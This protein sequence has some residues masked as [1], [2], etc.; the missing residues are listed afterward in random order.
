MALAL[1]VVVGPRLLAEGLEVRPRD[2]FAL[3]RRAACGAAGSAAE[4]A[5]AEAQ[6]AAAAPP[7]PAHAGAASAATP[8]PSAAAAAAAAGRAHAADGAWRAAVGSAPVAAAWER[9]C[10]AVVQEFVY[11]S[12]YAAV[13]PDTEF[14]A[15]VRRLLNAAFGEVARRA[16]SQRVDWGAVL[17]RWAARGAQG[18]TTAAVGGDVA[19][20]ARASGA[21]RRWPVA[22][23]L[24]VACC[25][26][27][28]RVAAAH[29][30]RTSRPSPQQRLEG[31]VRRDPA[32]PACRAACRRPRR[33]PRGAACGA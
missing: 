11:D 19:A 25:V 10:G 14:P 5:D 6:A 20:A 9:L 13:T 28:N 8:A 33:A 22:A 12:W 4:G 1:C 15:E 30:C 31:A 18:S 26:A 23:C 2:P 29:L 16:R 24:H 32:A 7:D 27:R 17:V 21:G 3:R